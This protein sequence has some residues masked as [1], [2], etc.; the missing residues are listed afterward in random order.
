MFSNPRKGFSP[1]LDASRPVYAAKNAGTSTSA[2]LLAIL[3]CDFS[4]GLP[5]KFVG[6]NPAFGYT[7]P[8]YCCCTRE[9]ITLRL[10]KN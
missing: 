3:P 9:L 5:R 6:I 1:T 8:S 2:V 10:F 4:Y 7:M